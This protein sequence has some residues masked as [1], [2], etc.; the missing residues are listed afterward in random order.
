MASNT[1]VPIST[2]VSFS[3][4]DLPPLQL[5]RVVSVIHLS[6]AMSG[7]KPLLSQRKPRYHR[8]RAGR[9]TGWARPKIP[10]RSSAGSTEQ[11]MFQPREGACCP[12]LLW[13]PCDSERDKDGAE[14]GCKCRPDL[15]GCW[16]PI[17]LD[18]DQAVDNIS[19]K[20]QQGQEE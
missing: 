20:A 19:S 5:Y 2:L 16:V 9:L 11:S 18:S 3:F 6:S 14:L 17:S 12:L 8:A 10:P 15:L 4:T 13:H 7:Q 1:A